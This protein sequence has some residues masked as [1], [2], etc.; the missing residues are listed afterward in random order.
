MWPSI[1]YILSLQSLEKPLKINVLCAFRGSFRLCS[2]CEK[3]TQCSQLHMA[4]LLCSCREERGYRNYRLRS[5]HLVIIRQNVCF[6][7]Q[8]CN[9]HQLISSSTTQKM[10]TEPI[11][12]SSHSLHISGI[13]ALSVA[14]LKPYSC[15]LTIPVLLVL[16]LSK[17]NYA[18]YYG[19]VLLWG[20]VCMAVSQ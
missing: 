1:I 6:R 18:V 8:V 19:T 11:R 5:I 3:R 12:Q 14:F 9:L 2:S 15:T 10:H 13:C 20:L 4:I 16:Y 7:R 17:D